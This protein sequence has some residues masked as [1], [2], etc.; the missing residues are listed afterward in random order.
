MPATFQPLPL[1]RKT[2]VPEEYRLVRFEELFLN[3]TV[4]S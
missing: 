1:P 2:P 4:I 3:S